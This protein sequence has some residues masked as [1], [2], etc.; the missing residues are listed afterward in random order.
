MG[1][2]FWPIVV[3]VVVPGDLVSEK[4]SYYADT[5]VRRVSGFMHKV[6]T[7]MMMI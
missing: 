4:V 1:K 3:V 5:H 7:W 6:E 2:P